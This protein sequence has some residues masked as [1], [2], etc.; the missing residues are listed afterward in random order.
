MEMRKIKSG[1]LRAIGYDA[2]CRLLL[3]LLDDGRTLQYIGI[4]MEF[5][6]RQY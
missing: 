3:V 4:G 2:C 1:R 5:L 6:S